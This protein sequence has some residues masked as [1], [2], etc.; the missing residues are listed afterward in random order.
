MIERLKCS[1]AS[2]S[3]KAAGFGPAI[4]RFESFRP[5]YPNKTKTNEALWGLLVWHHA[6][7]DTIGEAQLVARPRVADRLSVAISTALWNYDLCNLR[8]DR[9]RLAVC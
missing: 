4:R 3:G 5:S 1:G 7:S 2:P 6:E 9:W 8:F